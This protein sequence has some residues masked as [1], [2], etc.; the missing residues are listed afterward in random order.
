[1]YECH[2]TIE[3]PKTYKTT[4]GILVEALGWKFS[5]I[6]GDPT[7]GD[8]VKYYATNHYKASKN[9]LDVIEEMNNLAMKLMDSKFKVVRQ[10]VELIIYDT[11][12]KQLTTN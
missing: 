6:D 7:L 5:A 1:M 4:L 2:I 10:K 3:S 12:R 11:K 8:G 9:V